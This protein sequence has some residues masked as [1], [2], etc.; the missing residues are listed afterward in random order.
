MLRLFQD[1]ED[2]QQGEASFEFNGQTIKA[3][4]I[5]AQTLPLPRVKVFNRETV[6]VS[7]FENPANSQLAPIFVVGAEKVVLQKELAELQTNHPSTVAHA[8]QKGKVVDDAQRALTKFA[9][10]KAKGIKDLLTTNGG[11]FNFFDASKFREVIGTMDDP[12]KNLLEEAERGRLLQARNAQPLGKLSEV[13]A[14]LPDVVELVSTMQRL[15]TT[16]ATSTVIESLAENVSL[17]SWVSTGLSLHKHLMASSCLFC[18]E[19]LRTERIQQLEA[20]FNDRFKAFSDEVETLESKLSRATQSLWLKNQ[21]D[22]KLLYPELRAEYR[23]A[24]QDCEGQLDRGRQALS[25]LAAAVGVK[26]QRMFEPLEIDQALTMAPGLTMEQRLLGAE[27]IGSCAAGSRQANDWLGLAAVQRINSFVK[28]HNESTDRFSELAKENRARLMRD[29][30]STALPDWQRLFSE[31]ISAE[32]ESHIAEQNRKIEANRIRELKGE[33]QQHAPAAEDINKDLVSYLGHKEIQVEAAETGYRLVRDGRPAERLSE[34]ERT[35]IAF[36]YFLRSLKDQSF[37]LANGIVVIDDPVSS[38]DANSSFCAFGFMKSRLKDV[39]QLVILT[40]NHMLLR[41]VVRW[42][43]HLPGKGKNCG[44]FML[45][46]ES[47]E[48]GRS[49]RIAELDSLLVNYESDYHYLF[50]RVMLGSQLPG[51]LPLEDYYQL[52][53]IARRLLE[54]FIAFKVP[55]TETLH[56]KLERLPGDPAAKARIYQFVQAFSH[57]DAIGDEGEGALAL[58]EGPAVLSSLLDLV[59]ETDFDHFTRMTEAIQTS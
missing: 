34:G 28:T 6:A 49:S 57:D 10:D 46:C 41:S 45:R 7:I 32:E 9:T 54:T 48:S 23:D 35:A 55:S 13:Y 22:E 42:L 17:S 26:R 21:P 59:R 53:N 44:Y 27:L 12:T 4:A 16:T 19:P 24:V 51:Q 18:T 37:D 38:L 56:A 15:L 20:H 47:V 3:E 11:E 50:K 14:A 40:H 43:K 39:G 52:P 8:V 58:A 2:I 25:A 30:V 5:Q 31:K 36:I 29:A 33:I 1:R